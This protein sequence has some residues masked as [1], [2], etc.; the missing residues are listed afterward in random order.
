MKVKFVCSWL[1]NPF[2]LWYLSSATQW[3]NVCTCVVFVN[4]NIQAWVFLHKLFV[5]LTC[6]PKLTL[7]QFCLHFEKKTMKVFSPKLSL[8]IPTRKAPGQE[9]FDAVVLLIFFCACT[10]IWP[11]C[12]HLHG[13]GVLGNVFLK[14]LVCY[15]ACLDLYVPSPL[16]W[17]LVH[18]IHIYVHLINNSQD[19]TSVGEKQRSFLFSFE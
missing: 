8:Q 9:S 16:M 15:E 12:Y 13:Y 18:M 3:P 4:V 2:P 14:F 1:S 19:V 10:N 11:G 7:S 6:F 17:F 5:E